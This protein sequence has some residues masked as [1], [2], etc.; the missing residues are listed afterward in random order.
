[1]WITKNFGKFF[2][3]MGIPDH[4]NCILRKLYVGQETTD[5]LG[6]GAMDWFKIGKGVCQGSILS[7]CSFKLCAEDIM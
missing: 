6:H 5:R 2:K 7:P 3:N 1:M 4:H